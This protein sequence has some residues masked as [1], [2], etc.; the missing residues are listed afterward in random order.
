MLVSGALVVT[1]SVVASPP[2]GVQAHKSTETNIKII[3]KTDLFINRAPFKIRVANADG[4]H[5]VGIYRSLGSCIRAE[6]AENILRKY[7]DLKA[8]RIIG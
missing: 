6:I 8:F 5:T 2:P 1:A 3:S 7:V 4:D